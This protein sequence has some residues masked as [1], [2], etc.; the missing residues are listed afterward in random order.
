MNEKICSKLLLHKVSD[1]HTYNRTVKSLLHSWIWKANFN[2][3]WHSFPIL[4]KS[5]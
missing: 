1:F 3:M 2:N 4:F 5:V